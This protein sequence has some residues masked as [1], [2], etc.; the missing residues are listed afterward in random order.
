MKLDLSRHKKWFYEI[1][2]KLG[3]GMCGDVKLLAILK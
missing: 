2:M 3:G 1:Q